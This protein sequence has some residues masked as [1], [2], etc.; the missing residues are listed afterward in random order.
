MNLQTFAT[1]SFCILLA[2]VT[3]CKNL[4][5]KSSV[6]ECKPNESCVRLCCDESRPESQCAD[7]TLLQEEK[8]LQP[9][10]TVLKGKPCDKMYIDEE[11]LWQFYR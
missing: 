4:L 6:N 8:K 2:S 1:L 10:L 7:L 9:G 11:E 5:S 3:D